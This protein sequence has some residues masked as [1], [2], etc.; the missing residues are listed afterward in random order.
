MQP[1]FLDKKTEPGAEHRSCLSRYLIIPKLSEFALPRCFRFFLAANAGLLIMLA[2]ADLLLDTVLGACTLK[3]A[4]S[5]VQCFVFLNDDCCH[6]FHPRSLGI[7]AE[8]VFRHEAYYSTFLRPVNRFLRLFFRLSG[9]KPELLRPSRAPCR[10]RQDPCR[11]PGPSAD[12][13]RRPRRLPRR[14]P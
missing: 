14:S 12:V 9:G 10:S 1:F 2:L 11:R 3:S 8:T 13:R 7:C 6:S 5:A 4:Q